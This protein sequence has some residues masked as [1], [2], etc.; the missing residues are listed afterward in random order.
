MSFIVLGKPQ[1]VK[2]ENC[3]INDIVIVNV[4]H[5]WWK[6][7]WNLQ[8]FC[9]MPLRCGLKNSGFLE[10]CY[11]ENLNAPF[12]TAVCKVQ[13]CSFKRVSNGFIS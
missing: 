12:H 7:F 13:R 5:H 6:K 11:S 8:H 3:T 10:N 9:V 2:Q 4:I 1:E